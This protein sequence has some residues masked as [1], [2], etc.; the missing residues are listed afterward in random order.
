MA[1]GCGSSAGGV[2]IF[3]AVERDDAADIE[4]FVKAGGDVNVLN[5]SGSTPLWEALSEE[6]HA[7]YKA[8]LAHGADP[9]V[10]MKGQRVV[11]HWAA[12]KPESTWLQLALEHGADPNLINSGPSQSRKGSPLH[13]AIGIHDLENIKL[14]AKHGAD[15]DTPDYLDCSPLT[16]AA[17]QNDFEVVLYLLNHGADYERARCGGRSFRDIFEE[18]RGFDG[19]FFEREDIR[20]QLD[21]IQA[22]LDERE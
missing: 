21:A 22:W 19:K 18:R 8:L 10:I 20:A 13:F 7:R 12:A 2:D 1:I 14:L 16:R 11:T 5:F 17:L 3:D 9:N 6:K 15:V 4:T